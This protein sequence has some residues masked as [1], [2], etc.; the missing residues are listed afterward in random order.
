MAA[1]AHAE[2]VEA[3][4]DIGLGL[5]LPMEGACAAVVMG[6]VRPARQQEDIAVASD[7]QLG[8]WTAGGATA[9][10]EPLYGLRA[11]QLPGIAAR[12]FQ[13]IAQRELGPANPHRDHD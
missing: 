11:F 9:F 7:H 4:D 12:V 1:V 5:R 13:H 10:C 8:P 2:S 3:V 6:L